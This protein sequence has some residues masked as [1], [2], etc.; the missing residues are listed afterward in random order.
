VSSAAATTVHAAPEQTL[1]DHLTQSVFLKDRQGRFV[2][3]NQAFCA[4]LSRPRSDI[5]GQ[6]D[7]AFYPR[8]LAEKYRADDQQVLRDGAT[9]EVEEQNLQNGQLRTVRV[10]KSPV[11]G[12]DGQIQ[13]ILGIFWDITEQR[14]LEAQLRQAQKMAAVA[15]LAGGIAH[16]FNNLLTGILGNLSLAQ[17]ELG[18]ASWAEASGIAEL[19]QLAETASQRA[20]ELTRQL[21]IFSRRV[22]PRPEPASLNDGI[23]QILAGYSLS[24]TIRL[25]TDFDPDLGLVMVDAIQVQQ[26]LR[27]LLGNA[28]E[29]MPDGGTLVV[30]TNNAIVTDED[31]DD[32]PLPF[33]SPPLLLPGKHP[34]RRRGEFVRLR[35]SDT[36]VGISADVLEQLFE[37]FFSTKGLGRGTGLGLAMAASIAKD[38]GGWLECHSGAGAGTRCDLFLPRLP[39][40]SSQQTV[41][42]ATFPA[43]ILFVDNHEVMHGIG[44][45]ILEHHGY[46]VRVCAGGESALE[47]IQRQ[48]AGINLVLLD[49]A[50]SDP[51]ADAFL[52]ALRLIAPALP[53]LLCVAG[54][55]APANRAAAKCGVAGFVTKPFIAEELTRAV[56]T[57]LQPRAARSR[58]HDALESATPSLVASLPCQP[59]S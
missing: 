47:L 25:H 53:V 13:G 19:L 50:P 10:V 4:G 59:R 44:K 18:R 49:W 54:P 22:Q 52:T 30:Q 58:Q 41:E 39:A 26:L 37:P 46:C 8:G 42:P 17:M 12:A 6:D 20:A 33:G 40:P 38:H 51:N 23:R 1:L 36:G 31:A 2:A 14:R 56:R 21:L 16:D 3:V 45:A 48:H 28:Q 57:A 34:D 15:Q 55:T 27:H 7:F 9:R 35:V 43:T 5:L 24:S 29:A 32:T 11:R